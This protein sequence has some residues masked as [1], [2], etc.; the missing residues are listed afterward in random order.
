MKIIS[1]R[2]APAA[3]QTTFYAVN[4]SNIII[5]SVIRN[6]NGMICRRLPIVVVPPESAAFVPT[7]KSSTDEKSLNLAWNRVLLSRP[8]GG[9]KKPHRNVHF[10]KRSVE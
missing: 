1:S 4:K 6:Q 10:N 5:L 8:P 9:E 3:S 7:Q 2:S